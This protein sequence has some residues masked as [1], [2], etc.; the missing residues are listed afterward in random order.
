[1]TKKSKL[2]CQEGLAKN[3]IK[4]DVFE[5]EIAL[6]KKLSKDGTGACGWGKCKECGV[7]PLL[8]KL[9]KGVLMEDKIEI[10][11]IKEHLLDLS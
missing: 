4:C 11:S 3:V 9:H 6:C 7:I 5:R 10:K 1:M 2:T 8:Y